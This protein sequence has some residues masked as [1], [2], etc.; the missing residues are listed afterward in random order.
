MVRNQSSET[1]QIETTSVLAVSHLIEAWMTMM[2]KFC[3]GKICF[4]NIRENWR[5]TFHV[6]SVQRHLYIKKI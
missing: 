1:G 3:P 4:I 5:E 6:I 2:G